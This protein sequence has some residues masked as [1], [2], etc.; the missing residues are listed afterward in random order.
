MVKIL[1][2]II[3]KRKWSDANLKVL[4]LLKETYG[5]L[6]GFYDVRKYI[7]QYGA[8]GHTYKPC[9]RILKYLNSGLDNNNEYNFYLQSATVINCINNYG[10]NR[11]TSDERLWELYNESRNATV[12][13]RIKCIKPD[14]IICGNTYKFFSYLNSQ[15]K[16]PNIDKL[17]A[18]KITKTNSLFDGI[19]ISN[20]VHPS[21]HMKGMTI[22]ERDKIIADNIAKLL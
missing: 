21:Y 18:Y 5:N 13:A 22:D 8:C 12:I 6:G 11:H 7:N 14:I 4:F 15:L 3:D 2:G 16:L 17:T 10:H 9:G 19:I 1:D 20:S